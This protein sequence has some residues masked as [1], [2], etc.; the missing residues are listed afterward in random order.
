MQ[1]VHVKPP[2]VEMYLPASHS[3]QAAVPV[4]GAIRPEGQ[5]EQIEEPSTAVKRPAGQA[6]H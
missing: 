6:M 3:S 2:L 1:L 5:A 4:E